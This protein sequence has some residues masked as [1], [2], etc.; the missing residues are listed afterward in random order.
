M[1]V[2]SAHHVTG[3]PRIAVTC[4]TPGCPESLYIAP[5]VSLSIYGGTIV[6]REMGWHLGDYTAGALAVAANCPA[7]GG[8]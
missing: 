4:D 5:G 2:N 3:H 7:H 6:M 8:V 1:I